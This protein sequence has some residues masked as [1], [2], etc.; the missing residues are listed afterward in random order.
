MNTTNNQNHIPDIGKMLRIYVD[1]HRIHQ[2]AWGRIQGT[3]ARNIGRYLKRKDLYIHTLLPICRV[4]NYNFFKQIAESLPADMP[5]V[6][7]NPLQ[8][9]NAELK[10]EITDLKKQVALLKEVLA[11]KT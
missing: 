7:E 11:M 2:A 4:L 3:K 5:P 6:R 1:E 9:E 10:L 8:K